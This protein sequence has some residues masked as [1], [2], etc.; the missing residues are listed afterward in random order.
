MFKNIGERIKEND[1]QTFVIVIN[2]IPKY[3]QPD[4]FYT[5]QYDEF[6]QLNNDNNIEIEQFDFVQQSNNLFITPYCS[7]FGSDTDSEK[8]QAIDGKVKFSYKI[9][10]KHHIITVVLED[11]TFQMKNKQ[12]F[13]LKKVV[14]N[15]VDVSTYPG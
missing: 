9:T 14:F 5:F 4:T 7:C 2:H 8:F 1:K 6:K 15:N 10:E 13:K 11:F 3:F 12:P